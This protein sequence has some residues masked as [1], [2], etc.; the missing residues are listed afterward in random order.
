MAT[1]T[2]QGFPIEH[3]IT[4]RQQYA[5]SETFFL[6]KRDGTWYD[7]TGFTAL[8]QVRE[9]PEDET[10]L[11]ELSTENGRILTGYSTT[12]DDVAYEGGVIISAT[13]SD[14]DS[15]L[16]PAGMVAGY[17]LKL[18]PPSGTEDAEPLAE[19]RFCVQGAYSRG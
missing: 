12:V 2:E 8:L 13:A 3:D 5:W 15:T 17:D 11:L 19:G 16:L 18:I 9:T 14:M 7:T 4:A 6:E 10:V 1:G